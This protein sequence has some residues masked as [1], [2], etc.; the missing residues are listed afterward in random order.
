MFIYK[1][2]IGYTILKPYEVKTM[3][4]GMCAPQS[5]GNCG[6]RN[7]LTKEE[8]AEMLK[9]Y[10]ETLEKEAKAVSERIDELKKGN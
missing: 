8:K 2:Y 10:K 4:Y 9:E 1:S 5:A 7:F 6:P 3:G